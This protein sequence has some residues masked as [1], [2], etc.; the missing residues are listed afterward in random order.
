MNN[1]GFVIFVAVLA[2]GAAVLQGRFMGNMDQ[3]MG[4]WESVF[5]T[6]GSGGLLVGLFMLYLRGGNLTLWQEVPWYSFFAGVMGLVIVSGIGYAVPRL[7][8]VGTFTGFTAAQFIL[9]AIFDHF[10]WLTTDIRPLGA[11]Q[12]MGMAILLL[13]AWLILR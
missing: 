7:G 1:L 10:G 4:T 5:I 9:A 3:A 13:G 8:L 6:Y 12:L 11:S 2:G